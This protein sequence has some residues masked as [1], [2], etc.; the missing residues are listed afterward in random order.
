MLLRV[1]RYYKMHFN[2]RQGSLLRKQTNARAFS[3]V[4]I[5]FFTTI[6]IPPSALQRM[7][8]RR[9]PPSPSGRFHLPGK[10]FFRKRKNITEPKRR[11]LPDTSARF[12]FVLI[13]FSF[14]S[15]F[16]QNTRWV[17]QSLDK[18]HL[19]RYGTCL[20]LHRRLRTRVSLHRRH[21]CAAKPPHRRIEG[22]SFADS[23]RDHLV[24][25]LFDG[26]ALA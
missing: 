23:L 1:L 22:I 16:A 8:S 18:G 12:R 9:V 17:R 6:E 14:C 10:A 7:W 20:Y 26:N 25:R 3:G 24:G 4:P 19:L 21:L 13:F 15:T 2:V 5:A 11:L